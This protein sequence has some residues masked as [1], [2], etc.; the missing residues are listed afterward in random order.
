MGA[1]GS[2]QNINFY[3]DISDWYQQRVDIEEIFAS[4]GHDR[5]FAER[6]MI[7]DIGHQG[8]RARTYYAEGFVRA[9]F[10]IVDSLDICDERIRRA[11]TPHLELMA[12]WAPDYN[13][14]K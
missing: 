9:D 5:V 8:W 12:E 3:V 13:P 2:E 7:T 4:Q 6:R 1:F 14:K 10:K 11:E